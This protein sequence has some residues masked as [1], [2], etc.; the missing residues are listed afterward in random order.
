MPNIITAV[1]DALQRRYNVNATIKRLHSLSDK[2]L[3]DIAIDRGN[4]EQVARNM[5]KAARRK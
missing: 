5:A 4:I 2:Q 1:S 3:R